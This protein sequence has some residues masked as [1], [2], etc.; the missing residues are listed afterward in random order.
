MSPRV[1]VRFDLG[2][3]YCP[4]IRPILIT[5]ILEVNSIIADICNRI[6]NLLLIKL[7]LKSLNVSAQSPP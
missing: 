5:F 7:V 3:K 2:L 6:F 4:A 1:S